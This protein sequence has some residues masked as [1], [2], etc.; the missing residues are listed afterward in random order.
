MATSQALNPQP[1]ELVQ[2]VWNSKAKAFV[3]DTGAWASVE[4]QTAAIVRLLVRKE[5]LR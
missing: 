1:A 2:V 4:T 3:A 5:R